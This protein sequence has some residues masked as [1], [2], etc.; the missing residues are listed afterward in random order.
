ML[1]SD[2]ADVILDVVEQC[3]VV[4]AYWYQKTAAEAA[5]D[6]DDMG[7][8]TFNAATKELTDLYAQA[9]HLGTPI[10]VLNSTLVKS[11]PQGLLEM[12]ELSPA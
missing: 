4:T 6:A 3:R 8:R 10:D 1:T 2:Q 7:K 9:E 11:L 5:E 12:I